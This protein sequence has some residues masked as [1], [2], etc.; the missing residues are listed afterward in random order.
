MPPLSPSAA[1][2]VS[3]SQEHGSFGR[4]LFFSSMSTGCVALDD[5]RKTINT[6]SP[7]FSDW[8]VPGTTDGSSISRGRSVRV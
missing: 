7:S 1:P 3:P 8:H 6:N 2:R 5:P 4:L